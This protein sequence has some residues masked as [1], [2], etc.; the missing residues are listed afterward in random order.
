PPCNAAVSGHSDIRAEEH[1]AGIM[2]PLTPLARVAG[3]TTVEKVVVVRA[4]VGVLGDGEEVVDV[5]GATNTP[6]LFAHKAVNATKRELIP[7]PGTVAGVV[8]VALRTV[9]PGVTTRGINE[10]RSHGS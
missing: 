3:S 7:E 1:L 8:G 4:L 9:T 6:P 10:R 5:E 2:A